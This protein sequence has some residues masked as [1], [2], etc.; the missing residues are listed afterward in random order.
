MPLRRPASKA[1]T[2]TEIAILRHIAAG[3]SNTQIA[4]TMY[5]S[6]ETIKTHV[7]YILLKLN[8]ANRAHAVA[9]AFHADWWEVRGAVE[10][11]AE[12]DQRL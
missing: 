11:A 10:S 2:A 6:V 12:P 7:R 4:A 8:A 3:F 9:L 5:L 1:L